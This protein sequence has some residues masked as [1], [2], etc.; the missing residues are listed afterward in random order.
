LSE[1]SAASRGSANQISYDQN[2][3]DLNMSQVNEDDGDDGEEGQEDEEQLTPS[4]IQKQNDID[5]VKNV[6]LQEFKLDDGKN[7]NQ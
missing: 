1:T 3:V 6:E 2:T 4:K 7:S 5:L